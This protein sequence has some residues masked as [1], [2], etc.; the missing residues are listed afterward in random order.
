MAGIVDR[1]AF[2]PNWPARLGSIS[3]GYAVWDGTSSTTT[4]LDDF[5]YSIELFSD[6]IDYQ[7]W[8]AFGTRAGSEVPQRTGR[9]KQIAAWSA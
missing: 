6:T 4:I 8:R 3:Y 1:V 9:I 2:P 5:Y 7:A